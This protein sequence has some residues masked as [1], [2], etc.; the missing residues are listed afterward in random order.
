MRNGTEHLSKPFRIY[1]ATFRYL[2]YIRYYRDRAG[3]LHSAT[4]C[5]NDWLLVNDRHKR[6][7]LAHVCY[8]CIHPTPTPLPLVCCPCATCKPLAPSSP[9]SRPQVIRTVA[10]GRGGAIKARTLESGCFVC[11]SHN[12]KDG[13]TVKGAEETYGRD[14]REGRAGRC[15]VCCSAQG[16]ASGQLAASPDA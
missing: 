15:V 11:K 8:V 2:H 6:R 3:S 14:V 5:N 1:S 10:G 4:R 16:T 13:T 9:A 7:P 12:I